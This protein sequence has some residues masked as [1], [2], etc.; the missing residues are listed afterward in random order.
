MAEDRSI[1]RFPGYEE[2]IAEIPARSHD[3]PHRFAFV[4]QRWVDSG[5]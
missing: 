1:S 5:R 3:Q 4:K 2:Q